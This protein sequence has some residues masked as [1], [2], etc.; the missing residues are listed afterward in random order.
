MREIMRIMMMV[1]SFEAMG[2]PRDKCSFESYSLLFPRSMLIVMSV[3]ARKNTDKNYGPGLLGRRPV[4]DGC[5][6][7]RCSSDGPLFQDF[8][9]QQNPKKTVAIVV[10]Q[11]CPRVRL[12]D[13]TTDKHSFISQF[14]TSLYESTEG[15]WSA[16]ADDYEQRNVRKSA[17]DYNM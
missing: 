1:I 4:S 2:F 9:A 5:C 12:A 16:T 10:V 8:C 13:E 6:S 17:G 7:T 15:S 11:N 14:N 3:H